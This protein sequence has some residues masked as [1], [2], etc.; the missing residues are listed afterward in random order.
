MKPLKIFLWGLLFLLFC[1]PLFAG[2][3]HIRQTI[4]TLSDLGDR[5]SGTPGCKQAAQYVREQF[6]QMGFENVGTHRFSLPVLRD[7]GSF[8]HLPEK[9]QPIPLHPLKSNA[10]SPETIPPPGL[11]GPLIYVGKGDLAQFNGKAIKDAILLM[12]L[13]SGK[14]WLHGANLG[15]KALIYLDPGGSQ[16]HFFAEKYELSPV[17]F[18]RFWL[19]ESKAKK[20]F[21]DFKGSKD[22]MVAP[23]IRLVSRTQWERV[24]SQNIYCMVQGADPRLNERMILVEG[25]YDSSAWV[26]GKSPGADQA[27]SL[28]A[29][30]ELARAF[31][32]TPPARSVMLV[33]TGGHGQSLEGMRN[34]VWSLRSRSRDLRNLQ[35]ELKTRV[36]THARRVKVLKKAANSG[37]I[38]RENPKHQAIFQDALTEALK[39]EVD[40]LSRRLMN[41]RMQTQPDDALI[42]KLARERLRLQRLVWKNDFTDLSSA[43]RRALDEIIPTAQRANQTVW[44]DAKRQLKEIKSAKWFRSA[45]KDKELLCY[46]SL[47]LSSHGDGVGGF[48][49]GWLYALRDRVNRTGDF[50]RIDSILKDA[51]QGLENGDLLKD[52]LRPS[53]LC[54]WESYIPDKPYLGG[55]VSALAGYLGFSFVTTHDARPFW[56]TPYDTPDR[57]NYPFVAEQTRLINGLIRAIAQAPTLH[58]GDFPRPG[59]ANLTGRAKRLRHGELFPD[60]PSP[61]TMILAFQGPGI[62]HVMTD[63]M[64]T[65]RL[66]G[67]STKKLVYDKVI[68]EGYRFDPETGRVKWAID[69]PGTGKSAYRVK[70]RRKSMET[71]LI[72]FAAR[73]L[74][75][76]NLLEPRSLRY[77]T[78]IQILDGR[79][80]SEPMR[81][82]YSRIDTRKSL[83]CSVQLEPGTPLKMTLSD[84]VL[85]KKMILTHATPEEPQGI[86]Y[87]VADWPLLTHTE[88]RVARDMWALL[89][90]RI[91]SLETRGISDQRIAALRDEGLAALNTAETALENRDFQT[92]SEAAKR[93]WAL[94]SRVYTQVEQ[95]Q[96][97]VLFGVLFYIALFV[98]FAFCAERLL[99]SFRDIHKRIIA[100]TLILLL[101]IGV[102]YQVHPAFELAYSP[103]VVILAFFIMGLSLMV[104]LIIF[105]RFESEMT[106]LQRRAQSLRAEEI[107]R[108]KAFVAAFFLGVSNL[109][110]R[111][112]RTALTCITLIILTFTI[113]SFTTVK[114]TRRHARIQY[115][116]ETPY[117]GFLLKN[118][119]WKDLPP[120]GLEIIANA[121]GREGTVAPRVWLED[122]DPTRPVWL[123]VFH[124]EKQAPGRGLVG[125]SKDEAK[126]TG[127]DEILVAGEWLESDQAHTVLLPREMAARLGID[128]ENPQGQT[129]QIWGIPFQVQGIFSGKALQARTDLDGEPLT[130][131]TFPGE[132]TMEMSEVEMEAMESGEDV[133]AFQSRYQ[134]VPADLSL[135]IPYKTLLALGGHL[136]GVAFRPDRPQGVREAAQHLTDRFG[137]TLFSGEKGG[138]FVYNASDT[139]NYSG[140]PNILIPIIISVLIVLNTMIGSVYERK[141]EIAVY[142]SV[143]LAPSHVSFL[144]IAEALAFGVLSV[145]LGYLLAQ[146]SAKLFSQTALWAGLTVNYSSLAGVASMVLVMAVVLISVI[147]PSR[148]A[149]Q[150]AIP[151]INRA[152]TLPDVKDNALE[153]TLPFL[154]KYREYKSVGGFLLS[155]FREHQD[156]SHGV[157]STGDVELVAVSDQAIE[158]TEE[159]GAECF[160]LRARVWLAPFD[161]GIMQK[162]DIRFVASAEHGDF[163]EI[164]VRLQRESGEAN[165]WLRINKAFLNALRKQL[166]V[167]RSQDAAVQA[168][169]EGVIGE[170]E[171]DGVLA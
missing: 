97:D 86:G 156:I 103:T 68:L 51:A 65:F 46:I 126:V 168:G 47:H 116:P 140:V 159:G 11:Q 42:D 148:M 64:G 90:P 117:Q 39:T 136:K 111:R 75:M 31:K 57:V 70:M 129:I 127:L 4:E 77:M 21:G 59:F 67:M 153:L 105:F 89:G 96:K 169:Y 66:K 165:A 83:I 32:Q 137:L 35:K 41:L 144:F 24:G 58:D 108:W 134:H 1:G 23:N 48:N 132:L 40:R 80:E 76:F 99:F 139:L 15:A 152:W 85:R 26:R 93:S 73:Q 38:P 109:R 78:K 2:E 164:R 29:L 9:N 49:R 121:F 10:I 113:M 74:S 146:T 125:L 71:D 16:K 122:A 119:N 18:P 13:D 170:D 151:D 60:Q 142:T 53:R 62:H 14:N 69:K 43:Q 5:S 133:Q 107:S 98:P 91:R 81:Y 155:Y 131:V 6:E 56:G 130:P 163:L 45:V 162:V 27:C 118:V 54:S 12:D 138:T 44:S 104:T 37:R 128:L 149:A 52:S 82:W 158:C 167:W 101:L 8:L 143:G 88:Y 17:R 79:R 3:S 123:P 114:T 25:F 94:A 92:H 102:V 120:E 87:Q 55:E 61:N 160:H 110:R 84:T 34:L 28:A 115:R 147:Y 50:S 154:M 135:I 124:G 63:A 95:T 145:V 36:K 7:H 150:I 22:G 100:F 33:A 166:L 30:L 157:F 20:L 106:L 19:P 171:A 72:M 141:R 161:F 112:I